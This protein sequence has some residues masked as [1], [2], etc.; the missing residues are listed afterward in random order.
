MAIELFRS[1]RAAYDASQTTAETGTVMVI[2]SEKVIGIS[3]TWPIAITEEPGKLHVVDPTGKVADLL[4]DAQI[5][6]A[7]LKE[8]FN[9][10]T[11]R[12]YPIAA[13]LKVVVNA[14]EWTAPDVN[15]EN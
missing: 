8:A 13:W 15:E 7:D 6:W 14:R 1:T 4:H 9:E 2:E 10:A 11:R 12:Q 5:S 3:W